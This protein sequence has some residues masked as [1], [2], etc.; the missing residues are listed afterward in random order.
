LHKFSALLFWGRI[1][2][3]FALCE[4]GLGGFEEFV[5]K[6]EGGAQG[7]PIAVVETVFGGVL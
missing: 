3:L 4:E 7:A 6:G 5:V 1:K 2:V